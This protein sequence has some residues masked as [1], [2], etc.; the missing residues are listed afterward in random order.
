MIYKQ[1][2]YYKLVPENARQPIPQSAADEG[3]GHEISIF[4][5]LREC[6]HAWNVSECVYKKRKEKNSW[7]HK[8]TYVSIFFFRLLRKRFTKEIGIPKNNYNV[9]KNWSLQ[10]TKI[11]NL[12]IAC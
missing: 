5:L 11:Y 8:L 4:I 6:P 1:A 7:V 12:H 3:T 10:Q 2:E 9:K